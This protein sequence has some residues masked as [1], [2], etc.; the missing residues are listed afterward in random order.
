MNPRLDD[1]QKFRLDSASVSRAYHRLPAPAPPRTLDVRVLH[2]AR[3][4]QAAACTA[5][6]RTPVRS[7]YLAPLALAA[8]VL[9][10]VAVVLAMVFG[11]QAIRRGEESPRMLPAAARAARHDAPPGIIQ[12]RQLYTSDPPAPRETPSAWLARI[13]ALRKAGSEAEADVQYRR[14]LEAYPAFARDTE[15]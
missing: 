5:A 11:P 15:W 10:S 3:T 4:A 12:N 1:L 6:E 14:F 7:Q 2:A 8:S 9:L 13:A